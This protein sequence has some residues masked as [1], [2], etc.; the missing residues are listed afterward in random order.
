MEYDLKEPLEREQFAARVKYLLGKRGGYVELTEKRQNSLS[1]NS[2]IHVAIQ[3][4]ALQVGLPPGE[5]K[6]VYFKQTCNRD[7][8]V[9]KRHD[10]ILDVDRQY[11]RSSRELTSEEMSV[12]IDRFLKWAADTAG[13][14]IPPSDEYIAVQR[15]RH[16]VERNKKLL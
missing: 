10:R 15:M 1:Q 7:L 4:F 11:L 3:F 2:Y 16:D 12:A 8:F 14:Y 13:V 9:R 5:V 6:D